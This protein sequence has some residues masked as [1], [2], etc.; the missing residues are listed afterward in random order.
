MDAPH[1]WLDEALMASE[2]HLRLPLWLRACVAKAVRD[3]VEDSRW[4]RALAGPRV[5]IE[6][7]VT[8]AVARKVLAWL[9]GA[10]DFLIKAGSASGDGV[11]SENGLYLAE[12]RT[13][14]YCWLETRQRIKKRVGFVDLATDVLAEAIGSQNAGRGLVGLRK[15]RWG[16]LN[17]DRGRQRP[18]TASLLER[19]WGSALQVLGSEVSSL[20]TNAIRTLEHAGIQPLRR[21]TPA[22]GSHPPDS[23]SAAFALCASLEY[24]ELWA[25]YA[26]GNAGA[27]DHAATDAEPSERDTLIAELS[28]RVNRL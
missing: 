25:G 28:N 22:A 2:P 10:D 12:S 15:V 23:V 17:P 27:E 13:D 9:L 26:P 11:V 14:F 5:S 6:S 8:A 7:L 24:P 20:E 1:R 3:P 16:E 19:R 4:V 21:T 18:V